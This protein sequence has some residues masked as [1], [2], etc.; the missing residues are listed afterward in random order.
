MIAMLR[1]PE[2]VIEIANKGRIGAHAPGANSSD[3][4]SAMCSG[5]LE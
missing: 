5:D 2:Y 3:A 1:G 4:S